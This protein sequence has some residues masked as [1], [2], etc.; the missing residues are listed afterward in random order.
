MVPA[1]GDGSLH[2]DEAGAGVSGE[3]S[4]APPV[5]GRDDLAE[6]LAE[7]RDVVAAYFRQEAIDPLKRLAVWLGFGLVGGV[8]L[9]T[10]L[11]LL[12]L[13]GLRALQTETGDHLSGSLSWSPYAI[14]LAG[15]L[16]V[17]GVARSAARARR[18][19]AGESAE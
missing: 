19:G 1:A 15:V 17:F 6:V 7:L 8:F 5:S 14:V 16:V 4:E 18:R 2:V 9:C 13:A 11:V 12:A 10:G 3:D